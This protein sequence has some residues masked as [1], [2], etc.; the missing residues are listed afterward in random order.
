MKKNLLC[1]TVLAALSTNLGAQQYF[2]E[3]FDGSGPGIGAFTLID[4]DA[5]TPAPE[6]DFITNAWNAIDLAG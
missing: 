1:L 5:R 4:Q 6:V 2:T 3:D